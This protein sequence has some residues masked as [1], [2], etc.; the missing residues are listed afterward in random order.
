MAELTIDMTYANALF[1]AAQDVDKVNLILEEGKA[2]VEV[3]HREKE[4][5][6]FFNDPTIPAAEKKTALK[7]IFEDRICI[8][9]LN[10][11]YVL[12]DKGRTKHYPRIMDSYEKLIAQAE[13]YAK[14]DIYSVQP[15]SEEQ[16]IKFE[17]QT[18]KLLQENVKLENKIDASLIGGVKILIDGKM[19]DASLKKRLDDMRSKLL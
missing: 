3:F 14:G 15:L 6:H 1:Q 9:H 10:L 7:K 18:G 12:V 16:R 11:L 13:G 5:F 4:F 8:E 2:M 17:E 19:L